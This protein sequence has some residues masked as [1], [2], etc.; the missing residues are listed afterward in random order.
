VKNNFFFPYIMYAG[1]SLFFIFSS[2]RQIEVFEKNTPIPNYE[3]KQGFAAEGTFII[4]DTV[5]AYNLMLVLRHTDAYAYNNIWLNVG[6]QSPGDSMYFQK[7]DLSL[8]NDAA[9]WEGA[10][11]NDIWEVRKLLN[12]QPRRFKK[13]GEYRFRIMHIMRDDPLKNVMSAGLRVEKAQ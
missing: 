5:A 3:W 8:G 12:G 4:A 1:C 10:G 9:G 13:K 6:L 2:C 7:I 11:M